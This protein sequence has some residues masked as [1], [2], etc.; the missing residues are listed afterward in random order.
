MEGSYTAENVA[1][2]VLAQIVIHKINFD[3]PMWLYQGVSTYEGKWLDK[4]ESLFFR[5]D[6]PEAVVMFVNWTKKRGDK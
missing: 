2:H 6:T 1:V 3:V 4:A 5:H